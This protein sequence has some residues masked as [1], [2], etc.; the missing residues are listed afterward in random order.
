MDD[1]SVA[2]AE[3]RGD[4]DWLASCSCLLVGEAAAL[5]KACGGDMNTASMCITMSKNSNVNVFDIATAVMK[6]KP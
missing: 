3:A 1:Q 4:A 2:D 6:S 5:L